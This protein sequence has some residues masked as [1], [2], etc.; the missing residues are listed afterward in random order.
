MIGSWTTWLKSRRL[1]QTISNEAAPKFPAVASTNIDWHCFSYDHC[2]ETLLYW[3]PGEDG[4]AGIISLRKGCEQAEVSRSVNGVSVTIKVS[5]CIPSISRAIVN[6]VL[7][8]KAGLITHPSR[9]HLSTIHNA[10]LS[11][12]A[13]KRQLHNLSSQSVRTS[14][15]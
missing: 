11:S 13:L 4:K 14:P 3:V 9:L 7:L 12:E 6:E 8:R 1:N 5:I 10:L 15:V 2:R